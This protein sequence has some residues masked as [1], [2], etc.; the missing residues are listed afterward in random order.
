MESTPYRLTT[1]GFFTQD[2][3]F[4]YIFDYRLNNRNSARL[5]HQVLI[6]MGD[7]RLVLPALNLFTL[8]AGILIMMHQVRLMMFSLKIVDY[9]YVLPLA[10]H[11]NCF[12]DK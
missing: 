12:R 4:D 2:F 11:L 3:I 9:S 8:D 5:F 7:L 1:D 10:V 6:Y